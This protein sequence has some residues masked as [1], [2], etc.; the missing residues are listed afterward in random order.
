M[1]GG[2]TTAASTLPSLTFSTAA[3]RVGTATEST[4]SKSCWAYW[5]MA[6]RREPTSTVAP[7]GVSSTIATAGRDGLRE[8]AKPISSEIATG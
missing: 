3:E 7:G 6:I 1:S 2:I 8:M 5:E 4:W